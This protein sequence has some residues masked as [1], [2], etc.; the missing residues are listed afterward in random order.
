MHNHDNKYKSYLHSSPN[1][2]DEKRLVDNLSLNSFLSL[3]GMG[4]L[5]RRLEAAVPNKHGNDWS[6][7]H[8][9]RR[10]YEQ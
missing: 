7:S 9:E 6:G 2:P 5:K 10:S 3:R 8:E 1:F 4:V